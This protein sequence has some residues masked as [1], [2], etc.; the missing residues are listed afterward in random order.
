MRIM[1]L[2]MIIFGVAG[3]I[4]ILALTIAKIL[5][6]NYGWGIFLLIIVMIVVF[7]ISGRRKKIVE[8]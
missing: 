2:G 7:V 8:L 5:K 6:F 1:D 3:L 4:V